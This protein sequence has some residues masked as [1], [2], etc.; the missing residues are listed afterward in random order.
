MLYLI[1][2]TTVGG[3]GRPYPPILH[4]RSTYEMHIPVFRTQHQMPLQNIGD[5]KLWQPEMVVLRLVVGIPLLV[6]DVV[7]AKS[8]KEMRFLPS[9]QL[10]QGGR[11]G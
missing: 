9:D 3:D 6:D 5:C 11:I 7:G 4:H 2:F 8:P 10:V 1:Y